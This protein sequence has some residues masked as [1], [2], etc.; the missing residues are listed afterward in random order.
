MDGTNRVAAARERPATE[1]R[2]NTS[3]VSRT[4]TRKPSQESG[5]GY[6][7]SAEFTRDRVLHHALRIFQTLVL[8]L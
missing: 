6:L 5:R 4:F 8:T 1:R 2:G 7:I 3:K